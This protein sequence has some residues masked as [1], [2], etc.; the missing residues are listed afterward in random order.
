MTGIPLE[1]L[2]V[3]ETERIVHMEDELHNTVIGQES[4][5]SIISGAIRR[6]RA[7]ISSP[8]HPVG[9]FIFLGPTGV[10]KTQLAKAL[11]KYLFGSEDS[12]IRIDMSD[13]MEKHTASRLVGAPPGYVG[14][15]EGGVLTEKVRRHPYSVVLLDEIEKAHPDIFNLLLQLLE[16][17]ELSDNLGHVVNFRNTVIIMTSNAG[18]R[19]ITS[20]GRMGF[21]ITD[22]VMP[23]EEIKS[24]AMNELKKLLSPELINRIDD[25]IVFNALNK[26]EISK[27]LD[28][29]LNELS[30][31]LK[32]KHLTIKIK[33]KAKEYLIE[34]G[35]NPSMGARPMKRLLRKE[36]EDPLSME[37][38]KNQGK[39]FD[40]VQIDCSKDLKLKVKLTKSKKETVSV[41]KEKVVVR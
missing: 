28:I 16:E 20:E 30:E 13:Y 32:E 40:V 35:Y 22:G 39:D 36:I 29:Q 25:V 23:Y 15:E 4:A 9:S 11:A 10:G 33:P 19:Q 18:A 7:G 8:K 12:L 2:T 3:S 27:I 21:G 6:S 38:L 14:Y 17:G 26:K 5:V 1:Q 37:I 24:G 34:N 41:P 31:R